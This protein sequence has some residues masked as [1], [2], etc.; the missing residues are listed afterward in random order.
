MGVEVMAE[1]IYMVDGKALFTCPVCSQRKT[2]SVSQYLKQ[3]TTVEIETTCNCG[4]TWTS[5]LERRKH[6]RKSVKL[7]GR[8]SVRNDVFL[9]E[10]LSAG[11][12]VG[13]GKMKV[14]DLSLKGL[15][16]E[17]KKKPELHVNDLVS[18]EFRLKD[19]K[20]TLIRETASVKSIN[21]RLVGSAF[22]P[23]VAANTSLGFF[24]LT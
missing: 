18:L 24:L 5:I 19:K 1:K 14:V 13:K 2:E 8:Y 23:E 17:L 4:H 20:R 11:S 21:G 6:Y 9:E 15:K 3:E 16:F 7:R 22:G 12:F 10:G